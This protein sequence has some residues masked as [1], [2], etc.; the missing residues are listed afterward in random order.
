MTSGETAVPQEALG[1]KTPQGSKKENEG[2]ST[3]EMPDANI[4][5]N[6]SESH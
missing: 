6:S 4:T 2:S 1:Q 3:K 5:I